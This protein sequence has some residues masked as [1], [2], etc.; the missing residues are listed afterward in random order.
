MSPGSAMAWANSRGLDPEFAE[1]AGDSGRALLVESVGWRRWWVAS[2]TQAR[3]GPS[4]PRVPLQD[5]A[6][7]RVGG[8]EPFPPT[9][10]NQRESRLVHD[11]RSQDWKLEPHMGRTTVICNPGRW[12]ECFMSQ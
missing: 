3:D 12:H 10:A 7:A 1:W 5:D 8:G 6:A 11:L 9:Q 2:W 4:R